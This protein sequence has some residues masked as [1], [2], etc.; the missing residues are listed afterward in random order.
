L[1][2]PKRPSSGMHQIF[3]DAKLK[4]KQLK[5]ESKLIMRN[6]S[7]KCIIENNRATAVL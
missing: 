6:T 5:E 2:E 4:I 1:N 7:P 3:L